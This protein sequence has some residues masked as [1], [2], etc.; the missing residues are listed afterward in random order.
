MHSIKS[1]PHIHPEQT[2]L[3]FNIK[4]MEDIYDKMAGKADEPHR[5]AYFT[6][7]LVKEADGL[8][9]IDFQEFS[10]RGMQVYFISPGQVHQIIEAQK[11]FGFALT[12]ST[13]FMI[14]NGIEAAFIEDLHLFQDYGYSPSA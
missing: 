7:L 11:S 5:H 8:H 1:Y 10:M 3:S 2:A 4:R 14:E 6:I 12:V 9:I 13:Q